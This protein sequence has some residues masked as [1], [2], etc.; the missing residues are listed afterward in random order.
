MR[1][2]SIVLCSLT[3]LQSIASRGK[4]LAPIWNQRFTFRYVKDGI[5]RM[6]VR[7]PKSRFS[8]VG[9]RIIGRGMVNVPKLVLDLSDA[10]RKRERDKRPASTKPFRITKPVR[11][12]KTVRRWRCGTRAG[13]CD[14]GGSGGRGRPH[15][16]TMCSLPLLM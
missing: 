9:D 7:E 1:V 10:R 13:A 16:V 5:L 12:T 8:G 3:G 11:M 14:D 6:R 15:L 4:S 2:V